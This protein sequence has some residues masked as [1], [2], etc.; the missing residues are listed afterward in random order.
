M[1]AKFT[2]KSQAK[3]YKKFGPHLRSPTGVEFI[4]S[5]YGITLKFNN[6][7]KDNIYALFVKEKSL[8]SLENLS[9]SNC[10]SKY[11]VEMHHI[12][13]LK[14]LKFKKDGIDKLMIKIKR[15]QIPLCR[16]CHMEK[17]RTNRQVGG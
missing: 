8:S 17:H 6:S 11:R 4:K 5:N 14:D 10:G 9:C 15:K 16:I 13:A 1:A 2:L 7:I 3:V 12:R